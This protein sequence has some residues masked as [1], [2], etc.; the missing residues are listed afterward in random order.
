M[1][2][3]SEDPATLPAKHGHVA[4]PGRGGRA[5]RCPPWAG[6]TRRWMETPKLPDANFRCQEALDWHKWANRGCS[7]TLCAHFGT[8]CHD[9]LWLTRH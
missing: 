8:S 4:T 2:R 6:A 3:N 1:T 5:D 9:L 7:C